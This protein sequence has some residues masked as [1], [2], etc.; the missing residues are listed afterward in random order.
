MSSNKATYANESV[1]SDETAIMITMNIYNNDK[2][3][4]RTE[5]IRI[6]EMSSRKLMVSLKNATLSK[7][8]LY[9]IKLDKI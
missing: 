9:I 5:I 1:V 2:K 7:K 6:W 3:I 4:A 8:K